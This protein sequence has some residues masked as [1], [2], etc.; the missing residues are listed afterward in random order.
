[1]LVFVLLVLT[2]PVSDATPRPGPPGF[3]SSATGS[4]S[5]AERVDEPE[6]AP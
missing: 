5:R 3:A 2:N 4:R 6:A 1:M